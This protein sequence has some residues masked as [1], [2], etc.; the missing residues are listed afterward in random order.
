MGPACRV[1]GALHYNALPPTHP[2]ASNRTHCLRRTPQVIEAR[3]QLDLLDSLVGA[4][5]LG[6]NPAPYRP[7]LDGAS[8]MLS[9]STGV[10]A[11]QAQ[12]GATLLGETGPSALAV[13]RAS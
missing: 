9:A 12:L 5:L 1:A 7:F 10:G 6:A 3:S 4:P 2:R 8:R 13:L 11:F